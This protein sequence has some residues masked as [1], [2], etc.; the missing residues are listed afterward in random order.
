VKREITIDGKSYQVEVTECPVGSPFKVKVNNKTR[1]VLLEQELDQKNFTLKIDKESYLV[2]L[3]TL[4]S[5]SPFSVKVNNMPF[6]AEIKSSTPRI[7]VAS[8]HPVLIDT[9][10]LS[11]V[12]V[13]GAVVAPMAGK[14]VG[15]KVK[16]GEQVKTGT[17]LCVLEAMKMENEIAAPKSGV[18][19]EILVQE[20]KAVNEG[21]ALVVIK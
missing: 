4:Q 16:K 5:R 11:K 19:H 21:D 8:A 18:V 14:I 13:E 20:G 9:P 3:P 2:E 15:V 7:S 12:T 1:E 10:R 17:V 6:T